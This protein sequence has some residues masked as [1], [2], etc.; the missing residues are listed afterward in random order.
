MSVQHPLI[1][2]LMTDLH[3]TGRLRVWSLLVTILGDVAQPRGEAMSMADL[4]SITDHMKIESG[5]VRT[6]LSRLSK[7][8]WVI[9]TKSGR[10]SSYAFSASGR[11]TYE[12][13]SAR[14]YAGSYAP[15]HTDWVIAI[16]PPARAKDRQ[17]MQKILNDTSALQTQSGVAMWPGSLAPEAGLLEQLGCL[18]FT[19]ELGHTPDWVKFECAPPKAE[20]LATRFLEKY[21]NLSQFDGEL[22]A[23][24]A[25]IARVLIMHD[26]RRMLLRYPIVPRDLQPDHWSMPQAH[27]LMTA[28]YRGL[29][30]RSETH[31]RSPPTA[32]GLRIL[33]QRFT[34][35]VAPSTLP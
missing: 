23:I 18:C 10:T 15:E 7:E 19:G 16:L 24:D 30:N 22:P 21:H 25:L 34:S 9:S 33:E 1:Q 31:W 32:K 13:A 26:W 8:G 5:A 27:T 2:P 28:V 35:D 12:T 6:A 3:K 11:A 14:V 29:I 20:T 4:L 17:T